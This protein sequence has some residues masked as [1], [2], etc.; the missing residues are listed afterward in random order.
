MSKINRIPS[1]YLLKKAETIA[2]ANFGGHFT[3]FAFTTEVKFA[4]GTITSREE[5]LR[6]VAYYD[7]NDAIENAIHEFL[8]EKDKN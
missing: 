7:I 3:L 6:L 1:K 4:F 5:I 2:A 8:I